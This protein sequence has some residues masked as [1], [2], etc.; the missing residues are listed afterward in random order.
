MGNI[1][2]KMA[3]TGMITL[4]SGIYTGGNFLKKDLSY[5]N[6]AY[7]FYEKS[8]L[9]EIL[10]KEQEII[11]E[12]KKQEQNTNG[13][14]IPYYKIDPNSCSKYARLSAKK[15][16]GKEYN[17]ANA[18]D[19]KYDNKILYNFHPEEIINDS[20][21]YESLRKKVID[22]T[23]K[24]G[25]ILVTSRDMKPNEYK[26]YR[27]YR[28]PGKDKEGNKIEETH[29][30]LYLGI[31]KEGEFEFLNQWVNKIEKMTINDF[32]HKKNLKPRIILDEPNKD[33]A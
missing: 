31:N 23:L 3:L 5:E 26:N 17:P 10:K 18:W 24:P 16:F 4:A 27:T 7:E 9:E 1:L 12:E 15:I 28:F 8:R 6:Q 2:K 19:L 25:M 21:I 22:G 30:I 13:I 14:K 29:A 33:S 20:I 32:K 11:F